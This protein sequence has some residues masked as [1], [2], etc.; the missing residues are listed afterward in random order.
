MQFSL[1]MGLLLILEKKS[2]HLASQKYLSIH[3]A[4]MSLLTQDLHGKMQK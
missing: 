4:P 1:E 2:L 3:Q